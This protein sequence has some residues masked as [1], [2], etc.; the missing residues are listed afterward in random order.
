MFKIHRIRWSIVTVSPN[1]HSWARLRIGSVLLALVALNAAFVTVLLWGYTV[2]IF[3]ISGALFLTAVGQPS[4]PNLLRLPTLPLVSGTAATVTALA[5]LTVAFMAAQIWYG[6]RTVLADVWNGTVDRDDAPALHGIVD[7]LSTAA[8]VP[9]PD[10]AVVEADAPNCFTVGRVTD[11]TVVVTKPLLDALGEEE[12][13]PVLAHEIAHIKHRDVTLMTITSLFISIA[14][15]AHRSAGLLRHAVFDRESLSGNERI[16]ADWL[17]P[18]LV[19]SYIFVAPVLWLFPPVARLANR[20]LSYQREFAADRGAAELT[21][22]PMALARALVRLNEVDIA[23][24]RTDLRKTHGGTQSL[25]FL[26]YDVASCSLSGREAADESDRWR[27]ARQH[28]VAPMEWLDDRDHA[29]VTATMTHPPVEARVRA[30]VDIAN[31]E[32]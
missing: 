4:L 2:A 15:R 27:A 6:Y 7:R 22:T 5:G 11:A 1:N 3:E 24:S 18:V 25:C 21:G 20:S 13:E 16:A 31:G 10:I 30:L 26:P 9:R 17:L 8:D 28:A 32:P 12:L 19:L 29:E 14:D 23:V